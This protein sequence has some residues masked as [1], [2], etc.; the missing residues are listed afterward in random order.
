M[1]FYK[2]IIEE[3][4][5]RPSEEYRYFEWSNSSISEFW[6]LININP[7]M[8]SQYYPSEYWIDLLKW[9]KQM[10]KFENGVC[11]DV[12]CGGGNMIESI[13]KIINPDSCIGVDLSEEDLSFPKTRCKDY[14]NVEFKVGNFQTIPTADNSIDLITSTE[15]LEHLF[16]QDF[17]KA[18][19]EVSRVLKKGGYFLCT[20][21][22]REKMSLVHCPNCSSIFTPHQHMIFDINE[23]DI[24]QLCKNNGMGRVKYY[25]S[26][27]KSIPQKMIHRI[28]KKIVIQFMPKI[29]AQIFPKRGVYAF[30]AQKKPEESIK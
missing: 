23:R 7:I 8:R 21:P 22:I 30:L 2:D 19:K 12:G 3:L 11:C 9:F 29:A 24:E 13:F 14:E 28:G 15:V 1:K 27:D 6:R 17:V 16:I 4:D 18:F 26:I 10:T 25:R 5:P 20:I